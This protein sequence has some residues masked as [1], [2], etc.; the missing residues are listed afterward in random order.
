MLTLNLLPNQTTVHS[1]T[2]KV[3]LME[4][5]FLSFGRDKTKHYVFQSNIISRHHAEIHFDNGTYYII[6]FG[7]T[8]GT[9]INHVKIIP[10]QRNKLQ[11]NDIVAFGGGGG[12]KPGQKVSIPDTPFYYH[13][14][15]TR[16]EQ[17]TSQLFDLSTPKNSRRNNPTNH[18]VEIP[19]SSPICKPVESPSQNKFWNG[20]YNMANITE[21]QQP[22]LVFTK[23]LK[24]PELFI[25]RTE[26]STSNIRKS[27]PSE[28]PFHS[29]TSKNNFAISTVQ[30][31]SRVKHQL[32]GNNSSSQ[33]KRT[34]LSKPISS[35]LFDS[36]NSKDQASLNVPANH[37]PI[38]QLKSPQLM[39]DQNLEPK[40]ESSR[41]ENPPEERFIDLSSEISEGYFSQEYKFDLK[42]PTPLESQP[43][44]S[45]QGTL[46]TEDQAELV[47]EKKEGKA[48]EI[49]SPPTP[50]AL[51]ETPTLE[52][53]EDADVQNI[54]SK[55]D[56]LCF[57]ELESEITC[58]ICW[59]YL[60]SA[61]FLNPCGH[62]FC[63]E[64]ISEWISANE[65]PQ[66][67][68]CRVQ[69]KDSPIPSTTMD[70]IVSALAIRL[71]SPPEVE[72]RTNRQQTWKDKS[73]K[74]KFVE[75]NV[76]E[77]IHER[78]Q[79]RRNLPFNR[80]LRTQS[81]TEML[82]GRARRDL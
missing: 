38:S 45:K 67:P 37:H 57:K 58:A 70:N 69:F 42:I 4:N 1:K 71:L 10:N 33:Q 11:D 77:E 13:C 41:H 27:E 8:N 52:I 56:K 25:H 53:Q 16:K 74:R 43:L 2:P 18:L 63:G 5:D 49:I 36:N 39:T 66:C 80:P 21:D 31:D 32:N 82:R 9:L 61:H 22:D 26:S 48:K 75:I 54:P 76:E 44:L 12:L 14:S 19:S 79:R 3:I 50:V 29:G 81:I 65:T 35:N 68:S 64:C 23:K 17:G 28:D 73:Q 20:L 55:E 62:I 30:Q 7:S 78:R 40:V 59:E 34:L 24:K 6:D 47:S 15:I 60:V 51:K 72:E 46:L